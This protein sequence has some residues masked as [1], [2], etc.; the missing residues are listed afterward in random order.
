M[1]NTVL[2][3]RPPSP[4]IGSK[5]D[6][7]PP[8]ISF[9]QGK[10]HI[11]HSTLPMWKSNR[12]VTV[13]YNPLPNNAEVLDDLVEYQPL[14]SNK[15]KKLEGYDTPDAGVSASYSWRGRGWMKLITSHWQ[16]L[17]YGDEDDGWIVTYFSKTLFT[18]AGLDIYSRRKGGLSEALLLRIRN[19]LRNIKDENI[20]I[21]SACMFSVRHDWER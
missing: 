11:T 4:E 8:T 6:F 3:F 15:Q 16:V 20:Q 17:G 21:L 2:N 10:W 5:A 18:P 7:V 14:K 1:A 13:T 9:L 19:D 12:N